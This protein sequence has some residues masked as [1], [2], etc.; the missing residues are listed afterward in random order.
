MIQEHENKYVM[1]FL[2]DLNDSNKQVRSQIL[3]MD[4]LPPINKVFSLV[5][6]EENQRAGR[7]PCRD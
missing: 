5:V 2:M 4:P 3:L 6:Q 7:L 1:A